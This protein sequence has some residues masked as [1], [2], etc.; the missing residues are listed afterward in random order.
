[1]HDSLNL[2][3]K[4]NLA[5]RNLAKP[6]LLATYEHER[7]KIAHDLINFDYEHANAFHDGD[8]KALAQNF[9]TNV[10]FISGVGAEYAANVLNL[11]PENPSVSRVQPGCLLPP[12][13]VTRYVDANP[14]DI[15]LDIP[16]L[17]QFRV[18]FLCRQVVAVRPFLT[19]LCYHLTS[20][21]SVVGR[22]T[23]AAR[24]SYASQP[25]LPTQSDAYVQPQRYTAVSDLFTFALV[26]ST[27]KADFEIDSDD[28][29]PPL[30]QTSKW[31]VYL[32][33]VPHMDTK[34]MTCIDKWIGQLGE[35]EVVAVNVRPDGYVGAI[36]RWSAEGN[37]TSAAVAWLED[38][39]GRF[40]L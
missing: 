11:S 31:T 27:P 23:A 19:S 7:R 1:M 22:T 17:G 14:V 18:Y 13:K 29:L 34:G 25:P 28:H 6:S 3:W 4:L 37:D 8:V 40:L 24:A 26:T 2:A 21:S 20:S 38:Y 30:L 32:D 36:G 9:L 35:S 33:D 10:R 16:P 15:Q 39:Y 12:A 5:I